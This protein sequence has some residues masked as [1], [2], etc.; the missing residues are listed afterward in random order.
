MKTTNGA[1]CGGVISW[2]QNVRDINKY[3]AWANAMAYVMPDKQ[4]NKYVK[5]LKSTKKHDERKADKL[6]ERWAKSQI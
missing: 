5:L 3:G 1:I 6:F 4:Y 2:S